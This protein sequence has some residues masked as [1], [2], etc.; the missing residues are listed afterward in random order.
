MSTPAITQIL[1]IDAAVLDAD[2]LLDALGAGTRVIRLR[3]DA[4]GLSQMAEAAAAYTGLDAIHVISHGDAGGL[5]L[6]STHLD[7]G[8]LADYAGPLNQIGAALAAGGDLLLYGCNV[9][10]GETGLRFIQQLAALTGADV[11]A[12]ND[13]TGAAAQGGNWTLE[14]ATGPI[15]SAPPDAAALAAYTGTLDALTGTDGDDILNGTAGNDVIYGLRGND[16]IDAGAGS[17]VVDGG[18]GNDAISVVANSGESDTVSGGDGTDSLSIDFSANNYDQLYW[19]G[20]NSS[21][22]ASAWV[23]SGSSMAAIQAALSGAVKFS[24][25]A[26]TVYGVTFDGVENLGVKA[27]ATSNFNDLLVVQGTG[28]Y[29]GQGGTDLL[30]ADWS[31][32]TAALNLDNTLSTAHTLNGSTVSNVERLFVKTGS[33][34]DVV[35]TGNY[36][37]AI[38]SGGGNDTISAGAGNDFVDAGAGDDAISTVANSNEND[39]VSGGSGT[40]SLGVDFSGNSNG[41]LDWVG[42]D[43]SGTASSWVYSSSSLADIQTAL[44]GAV[45][46]G[47]KA[48]T[49]YGVT[50]D[51]VENLSLKASATSN[52]PDLLVVQGTGVYDGQGGTDL[53]YADWSGATAA[54]NLDNTAAAAHTLNGSTVSNI[55]RLFVKTG[56]GATPSARATTTTPLSRAAATTRSA[57]GRAA[58]LSMRGRGTTRFRWLPTPARAIPSAVGTGRTASA[59]TFRPTTTTS[60]TGAAT[61]RPARLPPGCTP[62]PAWRRS[63]PR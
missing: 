32:A 26:G 24:V 52:F 6:G 53:L 59:S 2:P 36:D 57:P 40:D 27:S 25:Q 21:G 10:A 47:V 33:G 4:D 5:W 49:S 31:G 37:D 19:R 13:L 28:S 62:A 12:S 35:S 9:A 58:I 29:D 22:T 1:F 50:F 46:F 41:P 42:F 48:G 15:D 34:D 8:N 43:T 16:T 7:N 63:R 17:D 45:K 20:Y 11:A 30:Y 39:A 54:L 38:Y 51:G 44:G 60:F 18:A 55:E 56:S 23:Y 3:A 14:S 61:T